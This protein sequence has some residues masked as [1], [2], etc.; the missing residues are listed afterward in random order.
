M[1]QRRKTRTVTVGDVKIGSEHPVVI[2]SMTKTNTAD[3][4][5]TAGQIRELEEAGCEIVRVAVKNTA[6]AK[7]ISLIKQE[8]TI[9]IV[10]DIHFD[11]RL[12]V[13]AIKQ[14]ADKIRINPGNIRAPRDIDNIIDAAVSAGIPVR[15]GVNSGSLSEDTDASGDIAGRM[16]SSMLG[17]LEHFR[18]KG[19]NELVLSLKASEVPVTVAAYR[20]IVAECEYPLHLGVTA[21]G[22]PEDGIIRSGIG[23]GALLMDGIGDTVRV[24]LTGH[25][26]E[27]V[28]TAKRILAA[29]GVRSFGMRIIA[30]PTCGRCQVDLISIVKELEEELKRAT[31]DERQAT[32]CKSLLI[33]LMGCEVNGPGEA[34][35]ADIG[36]AFGKDRG[37]IF[38]GGKVVKTVDAPVAVAELMK[39]IKNM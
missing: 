9:S 32:N 26:V 33:A 39:M 29:S 1:T 31:S 18:K 23:I 28:D 7:A 36:I 19:F 21:A 35:E 16:V 3:V 12:A 8:T 20:K 27:E 4:S 34:K 24:S 13:E 22:L 14:G 17:Y 10:A 11:H 6:D 37:V 5:A 30:C 38:C 15:I 2:Q 25:P